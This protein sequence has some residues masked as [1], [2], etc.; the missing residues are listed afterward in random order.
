MRRALCHYW[1]KRRGSGQMPSQQRLCL[2]WVAEEVVYQGLEAR[3]GVC[4]PPRA[5]QRRA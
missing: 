5:H 3:D 2:M 1:T 4:Q